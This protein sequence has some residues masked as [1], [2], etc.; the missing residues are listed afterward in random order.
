MVVLRNA[1]APEVLVGPAAGHPR[2]TPATEASNRPA[3]ARPLRAARLRVRVQGHRHE[4][5]RHG[6]AFFNGRGLQEQVFG[7]AKQHAALDYVPCKR[8]VPNQIYVLATMLAH[9]LGRELQL[10]AQPERRATTSTRAAVFVLKTLG[11]IR[12]QFVRRAGA[13]SRPQNRLA[14]TVA[15]PPK[16]RAE[17]DELLSHLQAA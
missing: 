2:A 17:F 3:P 9:N 6:C 1:V 4:Q 5:G 11:T 16:A 15:A 10:R 12:D 7:E 8:L 13:L 14:L